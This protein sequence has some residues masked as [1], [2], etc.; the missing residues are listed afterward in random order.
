[1]AKFWITE[2]MSSVKL[3]VFRDTRRHGFDTFSPPTKEESSMMKRRSRSAK[4]LG[5]NMKRGLFSK[6]SWPSGNKRSKKVRSERMRLQSH[7]V[8]IR[9]QE[10]L[11]G[12]KWYPSWRNN[13][14]LSQAEETTQNM[15]SIG[16]QLRK[17]RETSRRG[18][19]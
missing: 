14:Y 5:A 15:E 16:S 18:L 1:M 19:K 12:R 10:T 9:P 2:W 17:W 11:R 13:V 8:L 3:S 4:I 7:D 6:Q